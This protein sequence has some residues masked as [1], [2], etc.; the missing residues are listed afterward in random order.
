MP[1]FIY[2]GCKHK[3]TSK[4]ERRRP[5]K[6]TNLVGQKEQVFKNTVFMKVREGFREGKTRPCKNTAFVKVR[7]G[8][9]K[10][11]VKDTAICFISLTFFSS[12]LEFKEIRMKTTIMLERS[13][14]Y[15]SGVGF[16]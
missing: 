6:T 5:M 11:P 15:L 13:S 12:M 7:E 4:S 9:V 2:V 3:P 16:K 10:G 14:S 8:S 1:G